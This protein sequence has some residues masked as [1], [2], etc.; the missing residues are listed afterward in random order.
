MRGTLVVYRRELMSYFNTAIAY[1]FL[2]I[3][4]AI[5]SFFFFKFSLFFALERAEMRQFFGLMPFALFI[6][7]PAITMRLWAEELR[8]GTAEILLTLPF[9]V[10]EIVIGKY[11]AALTVLALSL[12]LTI[13]I[14]ISIGLLGDPDWG[15]IIGGYVGSF[16]LGALFIALGAFVSALSRNQVVSL[17]VGIGAGVVLCLVL[18]P[19]FASYLAGGNTTLARIVESLGVLS[20]FD[21]IERGV[22]AISDIVYFLSVTALFL[23]L[24]ILWVDSRR[25]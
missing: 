20:H 1:I 12:L 18:S 7:A 22:L 14:P 24:N 23:L 17:L 8:V 11:L 9:T 4:V 19:Q 3:L 15:P 25:Y 13:G 10:S 16:L 5:L 2:P 6:F 21:S